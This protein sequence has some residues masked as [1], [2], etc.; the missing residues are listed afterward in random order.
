MARVKALEA[1]KKDPDCE[2]LVIA[3]KRVSNIL[4]KRGRYF[5]VNRIPELLKEKEEIELNELREKIA[6]EILAFVRAQDYKG[7]FKKL[8]SIKDVIDTLSLMR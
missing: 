6:P 1:F 4:R 3:F 5:R 2:R 8:T 7:A